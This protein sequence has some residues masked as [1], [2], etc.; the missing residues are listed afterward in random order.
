MEQFAINHVLLALLS[1]TGFNLLAMA[2]W[3]LVQ[4]HMGEDR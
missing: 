4:K 2:S 3:M 1:W